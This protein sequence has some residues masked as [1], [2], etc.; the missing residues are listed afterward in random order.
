MLAQCIGTASV[1][2]GHSVLFTRAEALLKDLGHHGNSATG[3]A[4][5]PAEIP[6]RLAESDG[7]FT[8]QPGRVSFRVHQQRR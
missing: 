8:P 5:A 2:A 4:D 7:A 1:R 6:N 3:E